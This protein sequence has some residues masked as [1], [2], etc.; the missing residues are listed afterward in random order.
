MNFSTTGNAKMKSAQCCVLYNP[1][2]GEIHHV[3]RVVT[4]EGAQETSK[5]ELEARTLHLAKAHG[6]DTGQ[7]KV[8]HV[9]PATLAAPGRYKVDV[10][11][12][13]LVKS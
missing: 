5:D 12:Y 7:M 11:T 4:I 13:R 10:K 1:S 8:L 2:N 6:I 9:D 3:H